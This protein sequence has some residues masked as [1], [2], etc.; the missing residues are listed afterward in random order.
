VPPPG[1]CHAGEAR[2]VAVEGSIVRDVHGVPMQ[3]LGVT[4]DI[5]LS[6]RGEQAL[7]ERNTQLALAGIVGGIGTFAFDIATEKMQ[8]SAGYA[9][10]H[11]LPDGTRESTRA[12]W[13]SRVHADDLPRLE[14]N[15]RQDI[16]ERRLDH[17]CE[18]RIV[19]PDGKTRWVEARSLIAYDAQGCAQRVVGANIDVTERKRSQEHQ[20]VLHAEL[21][22]R[23]KNVLATVSTVAARTMDASSSMQHFVASLDGRIRSMA[24]THELLSAARWQGISVL[25]L[26]RRELAPYATRGNTAISGPAVILKS[27]AGQAMG[28]VLHELATNAAKYGALSAQNGRVSIRWKHRLNGHP[29]SHLV[30]DWREIGG[31]SVVAPAHSGFGTSTIRDLIPYE[32][33]GTVDLAFAPSGVR[34]RL[35]LPADWLI[36]NDEPL[37]QTSQ[38]AA[39]QPG[40]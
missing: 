22:H 10:I 28:M 23:V 25:E 15:L 14:N 24:R 1:H 19:R 12:E 18:Y 5:T 37:S 9:A 32:F 21:D 3:L 6:N 26:V 7:A 16:A 31:P 13:R 2:W 40:R 30:L 29:R 27:E 34:C 11:G 20:H 33:G 38:T 39:K 17:F 4:R 8:V 35:E 36:N